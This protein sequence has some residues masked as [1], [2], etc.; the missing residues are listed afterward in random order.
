MKITII[1][2]TFNS[3]KTILRN[4]ES[5]NNQ[6]YKNIEHLFIDNKSSDLTLQIIEENSK[7]PHRIISEKDRGISDAFNKG[8]QLAS[9]EIIGILNSDDLFYSSKTLDLVANA[10]NDDSLDFVYGDIFFDDPILGSNRRKPLECPITKAMPFNHPAFFVRKRFYDHLGLYDLSYKH[11][12]DFEL[13]SRMYTSPT[14]YYL[15]GQSIHNEPLTIMHAGGVSWKYELNSLDEIKRILIKK[16]F[17]DT[18][19]KK[20]LLKRKLRIH[21]RDLL[22]KLKL[23]FLI[24]AWRYFKWR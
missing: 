11:A 16:N 5:V 12:M 21:L 18:S 8:I 6:S 22:Q 23:T 17:Y 3:E 14:K 24:K 10:F 1:T 20:A 7:K 2:P 4:L 15:K 9:G 13:I 19:A